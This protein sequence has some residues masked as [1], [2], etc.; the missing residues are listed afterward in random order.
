MDS[1]CKHL[2]ICDSE[3]IRIAGIVFTLM[4]LLL[5]GLVQESKPVEGH[6]Y[7]LFTDNSQQL[8]SYAGC[9]IK[10]FSKKEGV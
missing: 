3:L 10:H 6:Q 4:K 5:E 7:Y 2:Q 1:A 8:C 9:F